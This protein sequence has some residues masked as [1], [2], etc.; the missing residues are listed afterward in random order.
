VNLDKPSCAPVAAATA[1]ESVGSHALFINQKPLNMGIAGVK[2]VSPFYHLYCESGLILYTM[3][4]VTNIY[5]VLFYFYLS[6]RKTT[7]MR[8]SLTHHDARGHCIFLKKE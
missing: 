5:S 2:L 4:K 7:T 1:V 3:Q 8:A 6:M